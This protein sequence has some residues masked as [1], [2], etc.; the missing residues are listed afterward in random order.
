MIQQ[1]FRAVCSGCGRWLLVMGD[2]DHALFTTVAYPD[3]ASSFPSAA[4]ARKAVSAAG[5]GAGD[6][7]PGCQRKTPKKEI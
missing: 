5:W 4:T 6:T 1:F 7:C 3:T 2:G